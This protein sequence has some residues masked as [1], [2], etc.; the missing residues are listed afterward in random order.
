MG[1]TYHEEVDLM[2]EFD[3]LIQE[4]A[5]E[6][7]STPSCKAQPES[8]MTAGPLGQIGPQRLIMIAWDH[9]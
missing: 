4:V 7:S 1:E 6:E 8:F 9:S 2:K 5:E 3:R